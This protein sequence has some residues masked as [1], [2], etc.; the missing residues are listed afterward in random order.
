MNILDEHIKLKD[1]KNIYLIYGEQLYFKKKY[2]EL[3][4]KSILNDNL[5]IMNLN[6]FDSKDIDFNEIINVCQTPPFMWEYRLVIV[7]D[8]TLF[9]KGNSDILINYLKDKIL[10]TTILIFFETKVDKRL[11][12]YKLINKIGSIHNID[13]KSEDELVLFINNNYKNISKQTALYLVRNVSSNLEILIMEI[14]KLMS[15][16]LGG[17]VSVSDI[18]KICVKSTESSIFHLMDYI[19]KKDSET[20]LNIYNNLLY[21]K[22]SPFLIL[23]ML[24]RQFRIIL[25]VKYLTK[26]GYSINQIANELNLKAFIIKKSAEQGRIFKNKF[27]LSA[28]NE[29]LIIDNKIK[30][31][32]LIAETAIE[33]LIIKYSN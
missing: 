16:N 15:Y 32:L 12:F 20:S 2:Q 22:V 30:T 31:G 18:D 21:N 14:Q 27:L 17:E 11:A 10:S 29:L 23:N 4:I 24:A 7:K 26:K 9:V 6:I 8:C 13:L 5:N 28:L 19:S 3:F 1:F 25:Q 33:L